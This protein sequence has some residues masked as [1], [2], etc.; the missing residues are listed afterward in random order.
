MEQNKTIA[1]LR[2]IIAADLERLGFAASS[3]RS[4]KLCVNK[5]RKYMLEKGAPDY[6]DEHI[7][8]EYLKSVYDYPVCVSEGRATSWIYTISTS[9]NRLAE[10]GLYGAVKVD[11]CKKKR[12]I[13]SWAR[14]DEH[15]VTEFFALDRK[16]GNSKNTTA[17]RRNSLQ[18]FYEYLVF[19]NIASAKAVTEDILSGYATSCE[20]YS[21]NYV[22]VL[23][24][25]VRV[26]LNYL[27]SQGYISNDISQTVPKVRSRQNL[28]MPAL[29]SKEELTQLLNS[30]D[31]GNATGKRDYAILLLLIQYGIRASDVAGLKL[32]HLNWQRRTIEFAQHKTGRKVSYPIIDNVGWALIEYLRDGRPKIDNLYVFLIHVGVPR[33]FNDG[34]SL[35]GVLLRQMKLSGLRKEAPRVSIG[36]HSLRHA[37]ARRLVSENV[38]L[39][40][41]ANI[42]GDTTLKAASIYLRSDIDGLRECALSL[43]GISLC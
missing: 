5:F 33:E 16:I 17:V 31:R 10:Y 13:G 30:I 6:Y 7:A 37:V 29:W 38:D 40:T 43:E 4:F 39:Q 34:G 14:T 8:A 23:L 22:S 20:G 19:R 35:C 9:I 11:D 42:L 41:A 28:N 3:V 1:E 21:I 26:Y 25:N 2:D 18:N 15:W 24:R 12:N 32:E 27:F 36:P